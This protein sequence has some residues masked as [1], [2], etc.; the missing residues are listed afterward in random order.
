MQLLLKAV[1]TEVGCS[2]PSD[3]RVRNC[4]CRRHD[5]RE[6]KPARG[7]QPG[8]SRFPESTH[9]CSPASSVASPMGKVSCRWIVLIF[10]A[11]QPPRAPGAPEADVV[12]FGSADTDR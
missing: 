11:S 9:E 8:C 4:S 12:S 2:S 3:R 1:L 7:A 5:K 10:S 6:R